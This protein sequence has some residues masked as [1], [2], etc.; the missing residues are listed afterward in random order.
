MSG[1]PHP[2]SFPFI[3]RPPKSAHS[4]TER[5]AHVKQLLAEQKTAEK[6]GDSSKRTH[7]RG[8]PFTPTKLTANA[9]GGLEEAR[10]LIAQRIVGQ[11]SGSSSKRPPQ[12]VR[13]SSSSLSSGSSSSLPGPYPPSSR[14]QLPYPPSLPSPLPRHHP[15][16]H[17]TRRS[18]PD[19][20]SHAPPSRREHELQSHRPPQRRDR[21]CTPIEELF[22][23][24]VT[25][26]PFP[27][28][29]SNVSKDEEM[30]FIE[31][32]IELYRIREAYERSV[33]RKLVASYRKRILKYKRY[34]LTS[35]VNRERRRKEQKGRRAG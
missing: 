22:V 15:R 33:G 6:S 17:Y 19:E 8:L 20:S 5:L 14:P 26:P 34:V 7:S 4:A 16:S 18:S 30:K 10:K 31:G 28:W 3:P 2:M 32:E 9:T 1:N 23:Q 35:R 27:E 21:S 24:D 13:C 25:W 11:S 29:P 12:K